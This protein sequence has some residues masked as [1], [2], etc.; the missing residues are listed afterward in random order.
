MSK[1]YDFDK[2][3]SRRGSHCVKHD[4]LNEF[5]GRDDLLPLWVADMD[6]ETPD[7]IIDAMRQRL[8]HPVFGY[9]VAYDSYWAI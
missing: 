6:F 9:T 4:A 5:Y 2:P 8:D 3:V 7:F 1:I